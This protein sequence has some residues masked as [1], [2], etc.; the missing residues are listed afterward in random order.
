VFLDASV[1]EVFAN[2]TTVMTVRVYRVPS[3]PLRLSFDGEA[4]INSIDV[5][6]SQPISKDRL[7]S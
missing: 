1:L 6:Q 2:G 3:G 5:W 4:K 7:T